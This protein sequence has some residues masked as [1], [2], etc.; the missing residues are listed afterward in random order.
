MDKANADAYWKANTSLIRNLLIVWA[1][2][3]YGCGIVF[4][5]ALNNIKLFSVPLGFWFAHQG[6]II[7]FIVLIYVYAAQMNKIDRQFGV[8]D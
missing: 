2:V 3:S 6:A 1:V 8:E 4:A 7:I 5:Q